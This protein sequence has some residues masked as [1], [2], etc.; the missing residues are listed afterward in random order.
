VSA[1]RHI[2]TAF[3]V[4]GCQR[5]DVGITV[6]RERSFNAKLGDL[7]TAREVAVQMTVNRGTPLFRAPEMFS[8]EPVPHSAAYTAKADMY[9]MGLI[10]WCLVHFECN[11]YPT[12]RKVSPHV[13][14][15]AGVPSCVLIH[16]HT[17]WCRSWT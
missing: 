11:P 13:R 6:A 16:T 3:C 15:R 14:M 17:A 7:G 2:P 8:N 1:V 4:Y 5:H 12:F 9:A 10:V